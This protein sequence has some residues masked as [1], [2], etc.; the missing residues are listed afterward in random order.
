MTKVILLQIVSIDMHDAHSLRHAVVAHRYHHIHHQTLFIDHVVRDA[1]SAQVA[2]LTK[3]FD[4]SDVDDD[5][6]SVY[7]TSRQSDSGKDILNARTSMRNDSGVTN[8]S[9]KVYKAKVVGV[10][11]GKDIAVL[12]IDAPIFDLFPIDVGTSTGLKV[13][14]S[15]FAIGNPFGLDHSMTVGVISGIGREVKS[16]IGRPITNVSSLYYTV[17]SFMIDIQ[18]KM[19]ILFNVCF[20]KYTH[21]QFI[22]CISVYSLVCR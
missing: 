5:V 11:P 6:T 3:V 20:L 18:C 17:L 4:K 15:A 22:Q 19:K 14:Q 21:T 9:R 13:G 10:D 1:K 2:I 12:K 8:Y 16:P 7:A